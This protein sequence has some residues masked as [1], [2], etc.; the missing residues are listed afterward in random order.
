MPLPPV[1]ASFRVPPRRD[2]GSPLGA[3]SSRAVLHRRARNAP[4]AAYPPGFTD[5]HA[6][7]QQPGSPEGS[8]SLS[9][10][11]RRQ[12]LPG[13]PDLARRNR[14]RSASF[15][16]FEALLPLRVRSSR[17]GCFTT[18][19]GRDSPG[20]SAP[21]EHHRSHLESSDP[22]G[23]YDPNATR[24]PAV[25]APTTPRTLQP[26]EP[27]E[28]SP[29]ARAHGSTPSAA[30]GPLRDRAAPPLGDASTPSTL[31]LRACTLRPRSTEH[32]SM[33][34][35]TDLV[36]SAHS[37]G[38]PCLFED[39]VTL[40]TPTARAHGFTGAVVARLRAL[41]HSLGPS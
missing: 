22:P 40:K 16:D 28:A 25:G 34:A 11:A 26:P 14:S 1:G 31:D 20:R 6:R 3:T 24:P 7:A 13:H 23:P 38:V 10:S 4:R 37:H 17:R 15:V 29:N 27:G 5:H 12:A 9:T 2:R 21:P 19:P 39:L 35:A 36:R 18:P 33:R 30:S 8:S 32:S 41:A